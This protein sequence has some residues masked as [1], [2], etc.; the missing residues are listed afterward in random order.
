M[1]YILQFLTR[2]TA[3]AN[4]FPVDEEKKP[5]C[6]ES[7]TFTSGTMHRNIV[8]SSNPNI[9]YKKLSSAK[10]WCWEQQ[11]LSSLPVLLTLHIAESVLVEIGG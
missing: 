5:A 6:L 2:S 10:A 11:M 8:E 1:R 9:S 7:V 3:N 4:V